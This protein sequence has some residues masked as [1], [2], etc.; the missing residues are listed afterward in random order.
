MP[1]ELGAVTEGAVFIN[2]YEEYTKA[3]KCAAKEWFVTCSAAVGRGGKGQERDNVY[4]RD[5]EK[6]NSAAHATLILH[7]CHRP[8][9]PT[10]PAATAPPAPHGQ[11]QGSSLPES[12]PAAG[13]RD[14]DGY[15]PVRPAC[16]AY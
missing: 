16:V 13:P 3:R 8:V 11:G 12:R 2:P 5:S 14:G 10:N 1:I 7:D 15:R 6:N 4:K 9:A